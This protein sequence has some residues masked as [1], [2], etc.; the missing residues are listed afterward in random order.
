MTA[1]PELEIGLHRFDAEAWT[2]DLRFTDPES[3][4]FD[5]RATTTDLVDVQ[6]LRELHADD[7]AYGMVL[8]QALLADPAI[9]ERF[10][11]ARAVA[12][13]RKLPL[14]LR[15]FIG[16][17]AAPE[18]QQLRWET[19][20][21]PQE[22]DRLLTD[23]HL[24]FSRFL[25]SDEGVSVPFRP[26]AELRAL[27]VIANPSD[28]AQ[29]GL[30]P[31]DV[32]A[33]L[34]RARTGLGDIACT[35]LPGQGRPTLADITAHL[36]E[37]YDI[38]YLVCHGAM[39]A[40]EARLWLEDETGHTQRLPGQELAD[41]LRELSRR[42]RLVVLASCQSAGD[43]AQVPAQD[44]GGLA[45]L[46]PKLAREGI[47][48]VVAMQG[49]V[50]TRTV[51]AFMPR[52]FKELQRDGQIDRAMTV[53]RAAVCDLNRPD[54]WMPVLFLALKSGRIWY[55]PGFEERG[56]APGQEMEKWP[57][58][59]RSI[60]EERCTPILGP[61][62]VESLVGSRQEIAMRWSSEYHYPMAQYDRQ[63]LPQVA[64]YLAV[65]LDPAF[66]RDE[67]QKHLREY[68]VQQHGDNLPEEIHKQSLEALLLAEGKRR[69]ESD[70][71]E[72][73][74]VLAEL[75]FK[76]YV[77]AGLSN[78]LGDALLDAGKKPDVEL[79][80]W[81]D[82]LELPTPIY[83]KEPDY[84]PSKERPFVY[85]V[86]GQFSNPDSLVLTEDDYFDFL[87]G[88][89][90]NNDMIPYFVRSALT[91]T[92]LLFLGFRLDEWDFR[93]LFRSLMSQEGRNL[94]KKFSHVAVQIDPEEGQMSDPEGARRY[95]SSYFQDARITL[96]WGSAETF[97]RELKERSEGLPQ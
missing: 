19:L 80:R 7:R 21:E 59:L 61:G 18:L 39:R 54:W 60:Q 91:H 28:L 95:L 6:H 89:T 13:A 17:S 77:T 78:L 67:L 16:P 90:K 92:A 87:I 63:N 45:G 55:E 65:H 88:V 57:A 22:R 50:S 25:A 56:S 94:R 83:E 81:N 47:P 53:A 27:V 3:D 75:P 68:M 70:P 79:C 33:E 62:L 20:R 74:K 37:G 46:G 26:R 73:H 31:L 43:G 85:H 64:Q 41:R 51:D 48:A 84:L 52:F 93:V 5:S 66:V 34:Q 29:Y 12:Q 1:Y 23:E 38:L 15:L 36:R 24:L 76:I 11:R 44:D 10:A 72:P 42:P 71:S 4:G 35:E 14:R 40:G 58:L 86:F 82:D 30:A 32:D 69:R 97:A 49:N 9:R 2:V 96:Y 8:G